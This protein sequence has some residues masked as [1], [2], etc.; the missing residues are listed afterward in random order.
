MTDTN[1][2]YSPVTD[3]DAS[4]QR[5]VRI[6]H[7]VFGVIFLG[8]VAVWGLGASNTVDLSVNLSVVLPLILIVAGVAGLIAMMVNSSKRSSRSATD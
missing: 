2:D 1:T 5:G 3:E 6:T 8:I 7:L 4:P